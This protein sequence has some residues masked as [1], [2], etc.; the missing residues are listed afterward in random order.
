MPRFVQNR[1]GGRVTPA[2]L[3]H[4][5]PCGSRNG[6][7][8]SSVSEVSFVSLTIRLLVSGHLS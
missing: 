7:F 5:P 2:V 4:H 3:P 8:L 1:V 6:R